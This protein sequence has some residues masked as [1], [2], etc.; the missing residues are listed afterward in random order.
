MTPAIAD[1]TL[2]AGDVTVTRRPV[3][4]DIDARV[5]QR[6]VPAQKNARG[7]SVFQTRG[8]TRIYARNPD[9]ISGNP[10]SFPL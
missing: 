1:K 7:V 10:F 2:P 9:T 4:A 8:L 6:R 5:S 3:T